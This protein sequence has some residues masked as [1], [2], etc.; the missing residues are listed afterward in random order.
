MVLAVSGM[1]LVNVIIC[2]YNELL[3]EIEVDFDRK[4]SLCSQ[5]KENSIKVY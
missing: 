3:E 2:G 4:I 1:V 5:G